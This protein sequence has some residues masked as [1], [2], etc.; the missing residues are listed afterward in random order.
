MII[1]AFGLSGSVSIAVIKIEDGSDW[2]SG[3]FE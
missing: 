1:S 3:I 2:L